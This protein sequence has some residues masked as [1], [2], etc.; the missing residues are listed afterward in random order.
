[1]EIL[2]KELIYSLENRKIN[3]CHASTLVLLPDGNILSAW[4]G[5]EGEGKKDVEIWM[6]K[7]N[8]KNGKWSEPYIISNITDIPCWNPVL[9]SEKNNI[10]LFYRRSM[11]IHE[12]N[13]YVKRSSDSGI[14]WSDEKLLTED[15]NI[16]GRGPCKNKPVK[17][18]DGS[19]LAP[20]SHESIDAVRWDCLFEKSFDGGYSWFK[21][22]YIKTDPYTKIIQPTI[23]QENGNNNVH[24]LMRSAA[25]FVYRTDSNDLGATWSIAYPTKL[26]NNNSGI[27]L[28]KI[29]EDRLALVCNPVGEVW[30]VRT[31][32]DL[33]ISS[34]NGITWEKAFSL[35]EGPGEYSYPAII[36]D[37]F[38]KI[39]ITFT[40]QRKSIMYCE[41][42]L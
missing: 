21:T 16:G 19:I 34:D 2:K 32:L 15:D 22:D 9:Y 18:S 30:G 23:W 29:S 28:V 12:W 42:Q 6:A 39:H 10:T 38:D 41:V 27:D 11:K 8:N 36:Y 40:Y 1:M 4:F 35:A 5:G 26:P 24:A 20:N 31:P 17:L 7:R 3:S 37:G 13:T 33:L 14:T 25:G